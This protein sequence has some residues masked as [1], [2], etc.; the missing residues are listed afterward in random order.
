MSVDE[1]AVAEQGESGSAVHLT[2]DPLIF[3]L[4]PSAPPLW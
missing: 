3:V 4:T 1:D 2:H